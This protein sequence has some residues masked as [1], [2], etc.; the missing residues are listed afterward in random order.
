M[1]LKGQ[2]SRREIR[3]LLDKVTDLINRIKIESEPVVRTATP[4]R[5]WWPVVDR[6]NEE[7]LAAL[8]REGQ[9]GVHKQVLADKYGI[10]LSSVQ[11]LLGRF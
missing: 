2:L 11:R 1:E 7:Q 10:S 4:G 3:S 5:R 9:A 8:A 6:L